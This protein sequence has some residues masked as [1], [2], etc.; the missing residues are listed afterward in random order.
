MACV[1]ATAPGHLRLVQ[2]MGAVD[3]PVIARLAVL[4][5]RAV[6]RLVAAVVVQDVPWL[7]PCNAARP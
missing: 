2:D 6:Q 3:A 1:L 4:V 7:V 5:V